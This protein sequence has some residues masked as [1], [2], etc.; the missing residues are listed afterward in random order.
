VTI[1]DI[2]REGVSGPLY[3]VSFFFSKDLFLFEEGRTLRFEIVIV[4]LK[5]E[6]FIINESKSFGRPFE[7]RFTFC[8]RDFNLSLLCCGIP[9]IEF[10]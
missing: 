2:L 7:V 10:D 1:Y 9:K 5:S 6:D 8:S 3:G 4:L